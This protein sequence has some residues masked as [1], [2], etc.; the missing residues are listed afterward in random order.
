MKRS[1]NTADFFAPASGALL[2]AAAAATSFFW[3]NPGVAGGSTAFLVAFL[4]VSAN[5]VWYQQHRH[6][7]PLFATRAAI[8]TELVARPARD[9]IDGDVA[10]VQRAL[11][12]MSLYTGSVDGLT[13]PRTREAVATYRRK[14]GLDP[15]GGIDQELLRRLKTE[16]ADVTPVPTPAPRQTPAAAGE[17]DETV[18]A[19]QGALSALGYPGLDIDGLSGTRT[20]AAIRDF[21]RKNGLP[22]TGEADAALLKA[23][24]RA[25]PRG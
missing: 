11:T 17:P 21:Q 2:E 16:R 12:D 19:A 3:R 14:S 4:F 25:A 23:L 9:D 13:G 18:A 5:A 8:E 20:R 10:F 7:A 6:P 24:R 15:A 22:E 1:A